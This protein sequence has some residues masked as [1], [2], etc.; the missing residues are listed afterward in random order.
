MRS[1]RPSIAL[2]GLVLLVLM[3]GSVAEPAFSQAC[4]YFG[5][6]FDPAS[7]SWTYANGQWTV[8]NGRLNISNIG[9]GQVAYAAT[10]FSPP[11]FFFIDADV[12]LSSHTGGGAFLYPVS[13]GGDFFL[14]INGSPVV[15]VAAVLFPSGNTYLMGWD[16][17]AR[18][19][20]RS[21]VYTKPAAGVTSFG[22]RFTA[23][24]IVLRVN[25]QDTAVKFTGQFDLAPSILN[26]LRVMAQGDSSTAWFDNIC[27]SPV[28]SRLEVGKIGTGT[29][30]VT[31]SPAGINCGGSCAATWPTGTRVT[32]NAA[33]AAGS[34]FV[35]W[36]EPCTSSGSTCA[37][38]LV[39]DTEISAQ[40]NLVESP[41]ATTEYKLYFPYCQADP[42][43]FTGFAVS[44]YSNEPATL[45]WTAFGANG[46]PLYAPALAPLAANRQTAKLV[47]EIFNRPAGSPHS[48][49]LELVS[50]N[51][52]IGAFSQFGTGAGNQMDGS[53][54]FDRTHTKLYFT[55]IAD[56][57]AAFRGK[58][59]ETWLSLANPT[60]QPVTLELILRGPG[61]PVTVNRTIP[62][63]GFLYQRA[64]TLFGRAS[65]TG[66][67]VVATVKSGAGFVGFAQIKLPSQ[68]TALG[69]NGQPAGLSTSLYSAQLVNLSIYYTSIKL[70]NTSGSSI[71]AT[72]QAIDD[73]GQPLGTQVQRTLAAGA[74]LEED[75]GQL[76]N[77]GNQDKV[78]TLAV[79]ANRAGLVGDVVF[80]FSNLSSAAALPLQAGKMTRGI[81]S[82]VANLMD[83]GQLVFF[84]GLALYNPGTVRADVELRVYSEDGRRT[85]TKSFQLASKARLSKLLT[86]ADWMPGTQGQVKGY[87]E[88]RS[89]QPLVMQQLFGTGNGTLLSAVPP[90]VSSTV[91]GPS[92]V[93]VELPPS[94]GSA[95]T[96]VSMISASAGTVTEGSETSVSPVVQV[97]IEG[98]L[99][100][101]GTEPI[102]IDIPVTGTVSDP[103]RLYAK[104]RI[105]TG[106]KLPVLGSYDANRKVYS[107]HVFGLR[108][109]WAMGVV[110]GNRPRRLLPTEMPGGASP[111]AVVQTPTTWA[112]TDFEFVN[113]A[114]SIMTD[115]QVQTSL[116]PVAKEIM[117]AYRDAGFRSPRLWIDPNTKLPRIY[118][119]EKGGI[120]FYAPCTAPECAAEDPT[121]YAST[122]GGKDGMLLG[123]IYIDYKA[124]KADLEP[125][126]KTI[127]YLLAHEIF[128]AVQAGYGYTSKSEKGFNN[129]DW[130]TATAYEEGT[131]DLAGMTYQLRGKPLGPH[132]GLVGPAQA[133]D[134]RGVRMYLD[135]PLDDYRKS[136]PYQRRDFFAFL[137]KRY[138]SGQG[139]NFLKGLWE[140]LAT[141]SDR[142]PDTLTPAGFLPVYRQGMDT[143]L[144]A[145]QTSLPR[146]YF[147]FALER[148][149]NHDPAYLL[150]A[151]EAND[152]E[153]KPKEPSRAVFYDDKGY[154]T[155]ADPVGVEQVIDKLSP[156]TTIMA[157]TDVPAGRDEETSLE[158]TFNIENGSPKRLLDEEGVALVIFRLTYGV[159]VQNN[160]SIVVT[161]VSKP[162]QVPLDQDTSHLLIMVSNC[163]VRERVVKVTIAAK[164]VQADLLWMAI[165]GDNSDP[166]RTQVPDWWQVWEQP[167]A[168]GEH[169][170]Y[171]QIKGVRLT[172]QANG[173]DFTYD[174]TWTQ[175]W[176]GGAEG[177]F[178]LS[179]TGKLLANAYPS[180]YVPAEGV[181][182][183]GTLTGAISRASSTTD[184]NTFRE[185]T[186]SIPFKIRAIYDV[187]GI[188]KPVDGYD[189]LFLMVNEVFMSQGQYSMS[190][191]YRQ[192][193]KSDGTLAV[194]DDKTLNGT[195]KRFLVYL[196]RKK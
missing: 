193:R 44:N 135:Q 12:F 117:A 178:T 33:P 166:N 123:A 31:S 170:P 39:G 113:E 185:Y 10:N 159:L 115:Q 103:Q 81:F 156:L 38:T 19:W 130:S 154:R 161:D 29:G 110:Q 30:T 62:A 142:D 143:F 146:A 15:G 66:G 50:D 48:A 32:L 37:V 175:T 63:R 67:H 182:L 180:G 24:E 190:G 56:G 1:R 116:R 169:L 65:I 23:T 97:K 92:G 109:D 157:Y 100:V 59:A 134:L 43:N 86:D 121:V 64:S 124:F 107:V 119:L 105:S 173:T 167:L 132:V 125:S 138:F 186:L 70:V 49:W 80:G 104:V 137:A 47:Q 84:T 21:A 149:I 17:V 40:F 57:A 42:Q 127:G 3:L 46:T 22:I 195:T 73:T 118:I 72:F 152:D 20:V 153:M 52:L 136:W 133:S 35:A 192:Y 14:T 147:E 45:Q 53:V 165:G 171:A 68:K 85:G 184:W 148:S 145:R 78:G 99:V 41:S 77:W 91:F 54:P 87:V 144:R 114:S 163:Y 16:P 9:S 88:V 18:V 168:G 61:D 93:A 122:E 26:K 140:Q 7:H 111:Q 82:Q 60:N 129:R 181:E 6:N 120:S 151:A 188:A 160:P 25:R 71:T 112:A 69:F 194:S 58:P 28:S 96:A 98:R 55:R 34:T 5:E 164:P 191:S 155:W 13:E 4:G 172:Y 90:T 76:F 196:K 83:K 174:R 8:G 108:R 94:A 179:G 128:H 2:S 75:A 51:P 36:S 131:A 95:K 106:H 141:T 177:T 79:T 150:Y 183:E 189:P 162:V 158:L 27:A 74:T 126:G 176:A 139:L 89:S 101:E 11:D 102:R 187:T